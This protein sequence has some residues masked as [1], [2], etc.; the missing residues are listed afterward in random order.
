MIDTL[1]LLMDDDLSEIAPLASD[2][3]EIDYDHG[4]A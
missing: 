1:R 3:P 4:A 2:T